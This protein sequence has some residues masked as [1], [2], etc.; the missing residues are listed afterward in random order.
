MH[1]IVWGLRGSRRRRLKFERSVVWWKRNANSHNCLGACSIDRLPAI[2]VVP[3]NKPLSKPWIDDCFY[4]FLRRPFHRWWRRGHRPANNC[5]GADR[6]PR[7]GDEVDSARV[8][9]IIAAVPASRTALGRGDS[10]PPPKHRAA[11]RAA[12]RP[13]RVR[14]GLFFLEKGNNWRID[15]NSQLVMKWWDR[16]R[17][18]QSVGRHQ[19]RSDEAWQRFCSWVGCNFDVWWDLSLRLTPFCPFFFSFF[20]FS[21][22]LIK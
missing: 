5:G 7:W 2:C 13:P 1:W 3:K 19:K 10:L 18:I 16:R 14:R 12:A 17:E 20:L 15:F 22:C 11:E 8:K 6:R 4:I 21:L 9:P